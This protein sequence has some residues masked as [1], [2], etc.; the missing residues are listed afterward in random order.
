MNEQSQGRG[1]PRKQEKT[2]TPSELAKKK[3]LSVDEA[4]QLEA[5][6]KAKAAE[7]QKFP[8]AVITAAKNR[9]KENGWLFDRV[10]GITEKD[11]AGH[12]WWGIV[13]EAHTAKRAGFQEK[14][15][16]RQS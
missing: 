8:Q 5:A 2:A 14:F 12:K 16:I 13:F 15:I 7:L 4:R 3:T 10:C 11:I 1:R 9:C 6:E